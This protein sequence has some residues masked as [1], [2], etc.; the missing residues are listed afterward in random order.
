MSQKGRALKRKEIERQR[1]LFLRF[2]A[3]HRGKRGKW[4]T[5]PIAESVQARE[6]KAHGLDPYRHRGTEKNIFTPNRSDC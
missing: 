2:N 5:F 1:A 3:S 4:T 6:P